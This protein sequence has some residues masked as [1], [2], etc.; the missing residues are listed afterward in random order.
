MNTFITC[1]M[2]LGTLATSGWCAAFVWNLRNENLIDVETEEDGGVDSAGNKGNT[3]EDKEMQYCWQLALGQALAGGA[4]IGV[5]V[6]AFLNRFQGGYQ[7][8]QSGG[9]W[10]LM[11]LLMAG[12]SVS[13]V[14]IFKRVFRYAAKVM[15]GKPRSKKEETRQEA[16]KT[17]E[18]EL[19]QITA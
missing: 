8:L 14:A 18:P 3:F 17:Q 19:V 2:L 4:I 7:Q 15:A 16:Q 1:L 10:A 5:F 13:G 6:L 9:V 12:V 11:L